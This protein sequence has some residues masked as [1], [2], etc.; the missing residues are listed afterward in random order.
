MNVLSFCYLFQTWFANVLCAINI[1]PAICYGYAIDV[2]SIRHRCDMRM[3]LIS[4]WYAMN[5]L[6]ASCGQTINVISCDIRPPHAITIYWCSINMRLAPNILTI[7]HHHAINHQCFMLAVIR[8]LPLC[9]QYAIIALSTWYQSAIPIC[10][11][12]MHD[13][14]NINMLSAT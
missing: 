3:L 8:M 5:M 11:Q 1:V 14:L 9:H 7:C 10:Y 4:Y 2:K 13:R 12:P 6:S